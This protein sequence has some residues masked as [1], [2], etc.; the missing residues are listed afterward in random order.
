MMGSSFESSTRVDTM[1]DVSCFDLVANGVA[2]E[3]DAEFMLLFS[4]FDKSCSLSWTPVPV[5]GI[6]REELILWA[7]CDSPAI[8]GVSLIATGWALCEAFWEGFEENSFNMLIELLESITL[9]CSAIS[10][11][12]VSRQHRNESCC[13]KNCLMPARSTLCADVELSE[14]AGDGGCR[15]FC[16]ILSVL[17]KRL[18]FQLDSAFY[19][20][21][22]RSLH[23][24]N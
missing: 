4:C 16:P 8:L 7:S 2:A 14:A 21:T 12:K 3:M 9:F 24:Y 17:L 1:F 22:G 5:R 20:N 23:K 6:E 15:I 18:F 10:S 11:T 13:A 19:Q